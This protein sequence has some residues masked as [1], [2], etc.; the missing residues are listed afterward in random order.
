MPDIP[1]PKKGRSGFLWGCLIPI[2]IVAA[3]IIGGV[4]YVAYY[5]KT[6]FKNDPS[7]QTVLVSLQ[8]NPTARVVLGEKIVITG[9]PA[10]SWNNNNGHR[11]ATYTLTV[12]GSKGQGTANAAVTITNGQT[13]IDILTLTG[14]GGQTYNLIG[15]GP[16]PPATS[17]DSA[18][19]WHRPLAVPA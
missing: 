9:T 11:T 16:V 18:A 13:H 14:P 3:L 15:S 6:G 1:P 2:I 17:T 8:N 12:Q 19:L 7:V 5:M 10:Y 4:G